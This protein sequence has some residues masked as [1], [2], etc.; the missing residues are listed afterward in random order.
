MLLSLPHERPSC[1][2]ILPVIV[3]ISVVQSVK[4]GGAVCACRETRRGTATLTKTRKTNVGDIRDTR[5]GLALELRRQSG[6]WTALAG[7]ESCRMSTKKS[8]STHVRACRPQVL[9]H[10]RPR[11]SNTK[12]GCRAYPSMHGAVFPPVAYLQSRPSMFT[13]SKKTRFLGQRPLTKTLRAELSLPQMR[14][15]AILAKM[16]SRTCTRSHQN[17]R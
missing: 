10:P 12:Q 8:R 15:V 9:S 11:S 1:A 16:W 7:V 13:A 6:T 14:S 5:P 3:S 2:T 4:S 17:T